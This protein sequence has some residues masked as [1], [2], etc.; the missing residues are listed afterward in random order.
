MQR[1]VR[2]RRAILLLTTMT[3]ALV[4]ASGVALAFECGAGTCWGT[5][6]D[7]LMIGT[8]DSNGLHGLGGDDLIRGLGGNDF[9]TGDDTVTGG[10]GDDR[11][12]GGPGDDL[13]V[14]GS[15]EDVLRAGGG[16]DRV[17]AQDGFAD[18]I[19]CG[20]GSRDLVFFDQGLDIVDADCEA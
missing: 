9:L 2:V 19:S 7:D 10:S 3:V 12:T 1:S 14:G 18:S 16:A 15:G 8:P 17:E 13:V 5:E 11:V 20:D 6:G 4:A